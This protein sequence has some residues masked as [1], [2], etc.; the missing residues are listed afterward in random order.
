VTHIKTF[1]D[2][3]FGTRK[4]RIPRRVVPTLLQFVDYLDVLMVWSNVQIYFYTITGK[5]NSISGG[6]YIILYA[7]F[8][9]E[10]GFYV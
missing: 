7:G 3:Y 8:C 10:D 1:L 4:I 9:L 2:L 5:G 6:R